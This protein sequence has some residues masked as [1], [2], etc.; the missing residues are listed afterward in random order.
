MALQ[1]LQRC[2]FEA[3]RSSLRTKGAYASRIGTLLLHLVRGEGLLSAFPAL[4]E[5]VASYV[6]IGADSIE[7]VKVNQ[8]F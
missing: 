7:M 8:S 1:S 2:L 6:S 5:V 3:K 4:P